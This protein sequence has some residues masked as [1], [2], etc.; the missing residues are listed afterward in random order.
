MT[1]GEPTC[2]RE[3][4]DLPGPRR[5]PVVGNALRI[6]PVNLHRTAEEWCERYGPFF[7]FDIGPRR[8]VGI[9]DL[10][11]INQILRDRPDGFRRTREV[12]AYIKEMMGTFGVFH[13]EGAD[14][15][16]QRRLA[17]TAL[18]SNHLQRYFQVIST[19]PD[20][21]LGRLDV[22]AREEEPFD[23]GDALTSFTVDVTS[24]LAF[25]YDLNTLERGESELQAHIKRIF[26]AFMR[27]LVAPV[28]YW[29]WVRLP[30]DRA[31]DR[32]VMAV[33]ETV[34]EFIEQARRRLAAR[35]ELRESPENFLERML[36][37]QEK[38]GA[39]TDDEI[40]G[41]VFT[42]LFAG[43]DTTAH[44]MAWTIWALASR[45]QIQAR[46]AEEAYA[47]LGGELVHYLVLG[48]E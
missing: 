11:A 17:V 13:A 22:A 48:G 34:M 21:L 46:W 39:F 31:L 36:A 43:E 45:P 18:N 9:G 26:E 28:P 32:S 4:D 27:R 6:R 20:R 47:V 16:H 38:D 7:R 10:E 14:W 29:R 33:R 23:I 41:N 8:V 5:L 25:G 37:A 40:Y 1:R 44:T 12:L 42:L 30:A 24:T 19:C 15:R 35:P 3:L 2:L